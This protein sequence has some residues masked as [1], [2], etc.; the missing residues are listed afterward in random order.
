MFVKKNNS[1]RK[2]G[3]KMTKELRKDITM[4]LKNKYSITG[5]IKYLLNKN[6]E[7]DKIIKELAKRHY[8]ID[9][10]KRILW[11]DFNIQHDEVYYTTRK[12]GRKNAI[13][14]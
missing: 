1:T 8:D 13:K 10:I 7:P 6:I 4:L 12:R 11:M 14:I 9:Y 2:R 3:N 5:V